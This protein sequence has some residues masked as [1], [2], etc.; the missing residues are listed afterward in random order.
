MAI[1][2]INPRLGTLQ[3]AVSNGNY[4]ETSTFPLPTIGDSMIEETLLSWLEELEISPS[5]L[6]QVITSNREPELSAWL[7]SFLHVPVQI[8]EPGQAAGCTQALVTGTPHLQR[9]CLADTYIF[10]HLAW[11]EA[12][13]RQLNAEE[14]NF[15]VAHLDEEHQFAALQGQTV[16]DVLTSQDEGPFALRQSGALPFD[17]VLDLC[18]E[19]TNREEVLHTLH[20]EGGLA[21]YLG[22]ADLEELWFST[23]EGSALVRE[24]LIYQIAKEIG[25][26]A[27]VLSGNVD[28]I[29]LSGDLT[30]YKPFVESLSE[31]IDFIAPVSVHP[32]NQTLP[33]LLARSK[34]SSEE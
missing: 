24:A 26:L 30:K 3:V 27:T 11:A 31:R 33:A 34:V 16:L 28:G 5:D 22:L 2:A 29:I 14:T 32:G 18:M 13:L 12:A 19:A 1:L 23:A 4:Y 10:T 15:I 17:G 21:G 9:R 7:G 25:A 8:M 20:H 6:Q